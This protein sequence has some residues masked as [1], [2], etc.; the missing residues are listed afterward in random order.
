MEG[1]LY[2]AVTEDSTLNKGT[3][4][5]VRWHQTK[6]DVSFIMYGIPMIEHHKTRNG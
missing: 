6:K 5:T 1:R 2:K 3:N 4:S